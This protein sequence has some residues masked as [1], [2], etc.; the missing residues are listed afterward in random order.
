MVIHSGGLCGE[1]LCE[2]GLWFRGRRGEQVPIEWDDLLKDRNISRTSFLYTPKCV[3]PLTGYQDLKYCLP[4]GPSENILGTVRNLIWMMY[5]FETRIKDDLFR[6][7]LCWVLTVLRS[8]ISYFPLLF[9]GGKSMQ[10]W[11]RSRRGEK[12]RASERIGWRPPRW[13]VQ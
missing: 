11:S 13:G 12:I 2:A 4:S 1:L 10:S 7:S 5:V 6:I 9:S 8:H 3:S